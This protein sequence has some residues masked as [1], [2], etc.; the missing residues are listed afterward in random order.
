MAGLLGLV[1]FIAGVTAPNE[2]LVTAGGWLTVPIS[3]AMLAL[4]AAGLVGHL[5][6]VLV[7]IRAALSRCLALA[8]ARRRYRRD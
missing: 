7:A 8:L 3:L 5:V 4:V 1:L 2:T 6:D